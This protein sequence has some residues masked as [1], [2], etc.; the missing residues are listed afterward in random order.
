MKE[1]KNEIFYAVDEFNKLN[2]ESSLDLNWVDWWL[3]KY[4]GLSYVC[5]SY[6]HEFWLKDL[7]E[8]HVGMAILDFDRLFIN[9]NRMS[10]FLKRDKK[11]ETQFG[12][13]DIEVKLTG[14]CFDTLYKLYKTGCLTYNAIGICPYVEL[15]TNENITIFNSFLFAKQILIKSIEINSSQ[16]P[17][18]NRWYTRMRYTRRE[19]QLFFDLDNKLQKDPQYQLG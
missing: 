17:N 3:I 4:E 9:A 14:P 16:I 8:N 2:S 12:E 10:R 19:D 13:F 15:K 1:L 11:L 5:D 18:F 6:F 7:P